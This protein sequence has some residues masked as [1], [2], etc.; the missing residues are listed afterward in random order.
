MRWAGWV[1]K[2]IRHNFFILLMVPTRVCLDAFGASINLPAVHQGKMTFQREER[3]YYYSPLCIWKIVSCRRRSTYVASPQSLLCPL[4][5]AT[6]QKSARQRS[7]D[8]DD[9]KALLRKFH[10]SRNDSG[11]SL[12]RGKGHSR[13]PVAWQ[14][15]II[16]M[17]IPLW[18]F[19]LIRCPK[20][21]EGTID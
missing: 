9:E 8:V 4:E 14:P 7:N 6:H 3:D 5:R 13:S 2:E 17:L 10:R 18:H 19:S 16:I 1:Y 21:G 12:Q 11:E 20:R 15:I